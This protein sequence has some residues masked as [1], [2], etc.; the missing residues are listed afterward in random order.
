VLADLEIRDVLEPKSHD[1][2]GLALNHQQIKKEI[3]MN[4]ANLLPASAFALMLAG[5]G[6]AFATVRNC[7]SDSCRDDANITTNVQDLLDSHRGL[8]PPRSIRAQS[9]NGVVYLRGMVDTGLEKWTAETVALQAPNVARVV[10]S[11]E[12]NN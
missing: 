9:A 5:A 4:Q 3:E 11:I 7:E 12:E 10:N 6:S 2:Q 8:G 1:R